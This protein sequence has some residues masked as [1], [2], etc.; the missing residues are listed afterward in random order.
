MRNR[1]IFTLF[2]VISFCIILVPLYGFLT[3]TAERLHR[4]R[5]G[6]PTGVRLSG[7]EIG[8]LYLEEVRAYLLREAVHMNAWPLPASIDRDGM[9]TSAI[10][11]RILDLDATM[12]RVA[13]A[14]AGQEIEPVFGVVKPTLTETEIIS[15]GQVL[16]VFY[17]IVGG[18]E[19]RLN[20]IRVGGKLINYTLL[21]PGEVFSFNKTVGEPKPE[22][23]FREAPV[24]V[25][26]DFVPGYGGGI[27]QISTT[28]YNAVVK[29]KLKVVER[30]PHSQQV[31]YVP[32]GMDAA[33]AFD[34]L[35]FK[36]QN[37]R[38]HPIMIRVWVW[39]R[40]LQIG[41]YGPNL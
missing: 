18:T 17:T 29:A 25:G 4:E 24:I 16:G 22:R 2:L 34:Y 1:V 33:V 15:L 39:G 23:G 12:E 41:I 28:L 6:V 21:M 11:G 31:H 36:F 3:S 13:Q 27:C 10:W 19:D 14:K 35:D 37:T 5:Y 40:R 8:G 9:V 32:P 30:Y 38:A 7:E 20:N 26:E